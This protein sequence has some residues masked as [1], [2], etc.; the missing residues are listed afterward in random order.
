MLILGF[1]QDDYVYPNKYR[2]IDQ[3]LFL[4]GK[5]DVVQSYLKT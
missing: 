1:D 4:L 2:E 5:V 3:I